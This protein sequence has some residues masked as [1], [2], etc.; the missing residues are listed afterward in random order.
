M[1]TGKKGMGNCACYKGSPT[2][3][4]NS[5]HQPPLGTLH[6][7]LHGY[8]EMKRL[9]MGGACLVQEQREFFR[10]TLA[11]LLE[12]QKSA[13]L[14][15]ECR[16]QLL[17]PAT[18]IRDPFAGIKE[19]LT[20][21]GSVLSQIDAT[22]RL[23]EQFGRDVL[24]IASATQGVVLSLRQFE[25]L[26]EK[27]RATGV[28]LD[29][30]AAHRWRYLLKKKPKVTTLQALN[31]LVGAVT[32]ALIGHGLDH[33]LLP[34]GERLPEP[35]RQ[36]RNAN[37]AQ[38]LVVLE[39]LWLLEAPSVSSPSLRP[40]EAGAV[41]LLHES[42]GPWLKVEP[43]DPNDRRRGWIRVDGVRPLLEEGGD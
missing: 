43:V 23:Y 1:D 9:V 27:L 20:P 29:P 35:L 16:R 7:A 28:E 14:P 40:L 18:M 4:E 31:L 19:L 39:R 25:L 10:R 22:V 36:E 30:V 12:I 21:I 11:P 24:A 38:I 17:G 26:H 6:D 2:L 32:Q 8:E 34:Q 15:E 5:P 33:Y 41:L 42:R 37:P 3:N 13:F